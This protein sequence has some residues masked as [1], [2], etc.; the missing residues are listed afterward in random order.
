M[1]TNETA[2]GKLAT[3]I[4]KVLSGWR[5]PTLMDVK[6]LAVFVLRRRK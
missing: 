6:A 1:A 2:L 5:V 3:L 4:A